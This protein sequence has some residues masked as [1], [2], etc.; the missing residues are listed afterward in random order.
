MDLKLTES[1]EILLVEDDPQV[2]EFLRRSLHELERTRVFHP[3]VTRAGTAREALDLANQREFDIFVVDLKLPD[4]TPDEEDRTAVGRRLLAQLVQKKHSGIIVYSSESRER[5]SHEL[6]LLGADDYIQ[7][8]DNTE[9]LVD[10]IFSLW[11]RVQSV[12]VDTRLGRHGA[13][14]RYWINGF[15]FE[16]GAQVL[17]DEEGYR[18]KLGVTEHELIKNLVRSKDN[19]L[20]FEQFAAFVLRRNTYVDHRTFENV[21]Y[22]LRRKLGDRFQLDHIGGGRFKLQGV[23]L[24]HSPEEAA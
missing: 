24:A 23:R 19:V 14:P 7:K 20:D 15:L 22:R 21:I 11:R 9:F 8:T 6:I 2:M 10:K 16:P 17:T 3:N 1:P 5:N 4:R 18:Y 12:K 13:S